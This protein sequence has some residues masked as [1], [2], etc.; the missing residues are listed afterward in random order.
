VPGIAALV[1][2]GAVALSARRSSFPARG[3]LALTVAGTAA[4][5]LVLLAGS[6]ESFAWVRWVVVGLAVPAVVALLVG[7]RRMLTV[8]VLAALLTGAAG[9]S[10]YAVSTA[11][12]AHTGSIPSVGTSSGLTGG[13]RPE[14]P[15]GANAADGAPE[16][17]PGGL[18]TGANSE[19]AALL[20]GT[21]STWSAAVATSQSAAALELASGTS[22]MATGGWSGS[23]AAVT[24]E[25]F[26]AD[27]A[28]GKISYYVAGGQGPGGDTTSPSSQIATWGAAHHP[29]TTAGGQT[30][31]DLRG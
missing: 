3:T 30:V 13:E 15:P 24:L 7:P 12:V 17:G 11:S 5:S 8:G 18:H 31:Y 2:V 1:G 28:A 21:D 29:A 9:T 25:Q 19:L 6:T 16:G 27:V 14:L 26:Q 20:T 23:D 10:A 4:W 22:V